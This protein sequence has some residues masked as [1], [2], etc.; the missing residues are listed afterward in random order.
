VSAST[1]F[2]NTLI[3]IATVAVAYLLLISHNMIV[4]LIAAIVIASAI[5]PVV[6]ALQKFK[7][8]QGIAIA[9]VYLAIGIVVATLAILVL[10]PMVN[11]FAAYLQNEDRLA[12]RIIF[13]QY[14]IRQ[15]LG[16][17]AGVDIPTASEDLI[18][19][20]TSDTLNNLTTSAPE[21]VQRIASS[22]GEIILTLVM[23]VYWL[24][25]RDRA[26]QFFVELFPPRRRETIE[27]IINE[28]EYGMGAYVRGIVLVA[29]MVGLLNFTFMRL[30]GVTNAATI[31]T[32]I[33]VT[34]IIPIVGGFIGVALAVFFALLASPVEGLIVFVIAIIIQQLENYVLS[35]RIMAQGVGFDTI[36]VFLFVAV[37][38]TVGGISGALISV[39]I[40]GAAYTLV[41][42]LIIIPRREEVQNDHSGILVVEEKKNNGNGE[43]KTNGEEQKKPLI[44]L[45]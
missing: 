24:T 19:S 30:L 12:N 1:V 26:V 18:R 20:T 39:P 2:R 28:I 9:A 17:N 15:T 21:M 3:V 8:P 4:V 38:F 10:P 37:G 5:R 6:L 25:T 23:G 43:Q 33:A 45:P 44:E 34:T 42:Y 29:F 32:V 36:L 13:A 7:M 11:H 31:A 41:K 16:E 14:V 40:A 22:L 27:N 35:P